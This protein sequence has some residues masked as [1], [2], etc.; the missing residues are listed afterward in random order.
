MANPE[1]LAKLQ[2]GVEAWNQW[3]ASQ[4]ITPDL[5]EVDLSGNDL[6]RA[7][8]RGANLQG[9][10][11]KDTNLSGASLREANLQGA[12]LSDTKGGLQTEQLGGTDLTGANLPEELKK[13]YDALQ[14][15]NNISESARMLF[16]A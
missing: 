3:R 12:D 6:S 9:V 4:V 15:V 14:N 11:F 2:E 8:L 10:R 16:L 1:Q 5:S 7:D 13:L